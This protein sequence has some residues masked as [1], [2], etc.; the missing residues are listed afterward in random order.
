MAIDETALLGPAEFTA[1]VRDDD[2][3]TVLTLAG[4][5]DLS[6]AGALREVLVLPEVLNAPTV[7]IDLSKVEFL[8]STGVGLLVTACKRIRN[9][10]GTFSLICGQG[11]SRRV[12]EISGLIEYLE[13]EV[14]P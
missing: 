11:E 10:G 2:G 13:V 14:A 12:L 9:S 1:E 7:R 8:G 6:S 3:A 5:I 4:E